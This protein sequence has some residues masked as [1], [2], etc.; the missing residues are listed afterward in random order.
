MLRGDFHHHIDADPVDGKFVRH[1]AGALIDRA[2][3]VGLNVIAITCHESLPYDGDVV[4]YAA[5]RGIVLLRGMEATVD[6][7]HVL[8]LNFPEYPP[9]VCTIDD[10]AACKTADALVI[11]P[12]PF[13]PGAIAGG[14]VL[15]K[16]PDVFDA[17]E[18]SGLYTALTRSFNRRATQHAKTVG[19]PVVGNSD[20]HF[21]W[22]LGYTYTLL[23]APPDP[24]AVL[25]AIRHG[26]VQLQTRPLSWLQLA[27]FIV[28]GQATVQTFVDGLQYLVRVLR[29][30]R[31]VGA[32]PAG[33]PE[34]VRS[35]R[36]TESS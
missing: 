23:D 31:A 8:L 24:Q 34:V 22:Q 5:E 9:G 19:L 4:R 11:A 17:V 2:A 7:Q 26:R 16:R 12:H 3:A 27:R 6:G 20:T 36:A 21:L 33:N 13:Y 25:D 32:T 30:T 1:S 15:L 18:F 35:P 29:R 28:E 14:D 10:V